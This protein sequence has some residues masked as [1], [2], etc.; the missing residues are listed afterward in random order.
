VPCLVPPKGPAR[1]GQAEGQ[2]GEHK[3]RQLER[4]RTMSDEEYE[5]RKDSFV[6]RAINTSSLYKRKGEETDEDQLRSKIIAIFDEARSLSDIDFGW[7][8]DQLALQL[9]QCIFP[10]HKQGD[11]DRRIERYLLSPVAVDVLEEELAK[12]KYSSSN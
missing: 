10:E 5:K 9:K 6:E 3:T 12:S 7:R 8:K 2:G 11:I 1:F 4:V